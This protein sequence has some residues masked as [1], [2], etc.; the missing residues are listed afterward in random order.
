MLLSYT[1]KHR[2]S[3]AR[4]SDNDAGGD[5]EDFDADAD[6]A[7]LVTTIMPATYQDCSTVGYT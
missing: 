3:L 7:D 6:G 2:R 1:G 4:L 5:D